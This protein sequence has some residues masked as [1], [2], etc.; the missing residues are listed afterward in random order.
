MRKKP[1]KIALPWLLPVL[2]LALIVVALSTAK[3]AEAG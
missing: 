1:V 2:V 3:P